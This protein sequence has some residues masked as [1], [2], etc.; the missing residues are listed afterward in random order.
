[1]TTDRRNTLVNGYLCDELS[2]FLYIT[3]LLIGC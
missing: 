3:W 1:V 2:M